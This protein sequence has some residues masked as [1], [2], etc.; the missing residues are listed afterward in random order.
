[1][2]WEGMSNQALQAVFEYA[3]VS[4]TVAYSTS[5]RNQSTFRT[6]EGKDVKITVA[7]GETYVD[8]SKVTSRDYLTSNGVLQILDRCV[9]RAIS[10]LYKH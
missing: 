8:A 1:M 10:F 2:G 5:L 7:D 4:G 6:L 3:I 9:N